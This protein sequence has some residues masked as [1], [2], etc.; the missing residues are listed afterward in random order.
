MHCS[1]PGRPAD[2]LIT[3]SLQRLIE[4]LAAAADVDLSG[5]TAVLA[6]QPT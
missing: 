1:L 5:R 6:S 2:R 3:R 4:R